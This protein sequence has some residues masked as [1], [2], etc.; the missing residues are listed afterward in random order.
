[1]IR[2]TLLNSKQGAAALQFNK[3]TQFNI[4]EQFTMQLR[5]VSPGQLEL[6][7]SQGDPCP[8]PIRRGRETVIKLSCNPAEKKFPVVKS[9]VEAPQCL[10]TLEVETALACP[11]SGAAPARQ[12]VVCPAPVLEPLDVYI[13]PVRGASLCGLCVRVFAFAQL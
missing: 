2:K 7:L 13:V 8:A 11:T 4:G 6:S 5:E 12:S 3:K 10:Y 9:V 1:L